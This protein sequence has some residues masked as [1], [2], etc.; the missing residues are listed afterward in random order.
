M[1]GDDGVIG[2]A[3]AFNILMQACADVCDS[4]TDGEASGVIPK[5]FTRDEATALTIAAIM[6]LVK[7]VDM[8]ASPII[9]KCVL[10]RYCRAELSNMFPIMYSV[11]ATNNRGVSIDPDLINSKN[12]DTIIDFVDLVGTCIKLGHK[13]VRDP[14]KEPYSLIWR[15]GFKLS[16]DNGGYYPNLCVDLMVYVRANMLP[17]H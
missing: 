7:K 5:N 1:S 14:F 17:T 12:I 4:R 15:H 13:E 9:M 11:I 2:I 16:R 8:Q 6:L 3:E 10:S